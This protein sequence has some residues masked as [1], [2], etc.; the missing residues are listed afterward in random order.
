MDIADQKADM[1]DPQQKT[2]LVELSCTMMLP[3][4]SPNYN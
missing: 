2:A 1:N 4:E 3:W